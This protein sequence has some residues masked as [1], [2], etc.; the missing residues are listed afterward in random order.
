MSIRIEFENISIHSIIPEDC[1]WIDGNGELQMS[2][3]YYT[4]IYN[5]ISKEMKNENKFRYILIEDADS[6][7]VYECRCLE[8]Y[9]DELVWKQ[10]K[11][12]GREK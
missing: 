12:D 1:V 6:K 10:T 9:S 7:N 5:D 11:K 4:G 8:R 3:K 2:D